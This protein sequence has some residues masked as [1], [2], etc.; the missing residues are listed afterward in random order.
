M[1]SA[2]KAGSAVLFS[3]IAT[4]CPYAFGLN[5]SLDISQYGRASW[6]VQDGFSPGT[7][8][9]MAQTPDGYLWL[10]AEFGLFRFDGVRVI[11]RRPPA[12]QDLPNKPYSLLVT[13]EGTLWIGTF[14]GLATWS[15]GTLYARP[16]VGAWR[17]RAAFGCVV[18]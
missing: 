5:P 3:V 15:G 8:F 13:H 16:P 1:P 12:G 4:L 18:Q 2:R 6:T 9:T 11:P 10:G 7:I 14:T 17:V